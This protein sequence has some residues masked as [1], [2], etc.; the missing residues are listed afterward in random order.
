MLA[1]LMQSFDGLDAVKLA[2]APE[3]V[4]GEGEVVMRVQLAGLNPAD[5]YLSQGQYPARP[6]LPHIL[7]RDAVGTI[8]SLGAGVTGWKIGD[9]A[10]LL[11]S[12]VGVSR[13][14]TF[15]QKVAVPVASLARVPEGWTDEESAG[16]PL[17]YMTAYQA[18]AQFGE[19]PAGRVVLVSGASGGVG[20][21]T[22]QLAQAMG[23][24]VIGLS[25]GTSKREALLKL[26]AAAVY[27]PN[28]PAWPKRLKEFLSPAG[29]GI[30]SAVDLVIDN[31]G[32]AGFNDLLA[33][34]GANG[35]VSV[36]GR[37]AGPVP[38]FNTAS[39]F[40]RR[41][42]IKGVA[43]GTYTPEESQAAWKGVVELMN[44][45]NARPVVDR[46]FEFEQLK[47]AFERLAQG[48]LGKV[49]VRM[50]G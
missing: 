42:T 39:L 46:I 24:R 35:K 38:Q 45:I 13:A 40:F 23:H 2:E 22:I 37:L 28:A 16:G 48:P 31:V 6:E 25:R 1:W 21:A 17:V 14:G 19:L 29:G 33:T 11:R 41:L 12:E 9:R 5:R 8:E 50:K 34:L 44:K 15:A 4:A 20:I 3:P 7:G 43:V 47:E 27:D 18:L 49:L 26:G 30:R 32:G 36:V 10:L